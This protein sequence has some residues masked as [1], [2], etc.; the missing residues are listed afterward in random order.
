[1]D[2]LRKVNGYLGKCLVMMNDDPNSDELEFFTKRFV[3]GTLLDMY[4]GYKELAQMFEEII[5]EHP[6]IANMKSIDAI[7]KIIAEAEKAEE[8]EES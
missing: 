8:K 4:Y 7:N 5:A 1:M 3:D 2:N 6:E